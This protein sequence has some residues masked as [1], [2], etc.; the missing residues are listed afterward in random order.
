MGTDTITAETSLVTGV[1]YDKDGRMLDVVQVPVD[2]A[3]GDT[4]TAALIFDEYGDAVTLKILLIDSNGT[5]LMENLT[6]ANQ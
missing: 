3:S 5:P 4:D 1:I 2:L 6:L